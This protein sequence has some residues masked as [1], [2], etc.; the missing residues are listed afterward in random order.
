MTRYLACSALA[1]LTSLPVFAQ[2]PSA[3]AL[4]YSPSL[5][6]KSMD[7]TIDPCTDFYTLFLRWM[8]EEKSDSGGS[9]IMERLRQALPG[10]P[11]LFARNS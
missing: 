5:D 8:A 1:V 11:A 7:K 10:Q 9:D 6:I 3:A 4:P 2:S